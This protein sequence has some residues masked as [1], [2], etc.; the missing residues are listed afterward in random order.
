[1]KKILIL[2]LII[3]VSF[4]F[5]Q[6]KN[7][8][9]LHKKAGKIPNEQCLGCHGRILKEETLDGRFK[10]FHRVHLESELETP[11]NCSDC[12]ESVDLREGSASALRKQ[13]DPGLC[14]LCHSGGEKGLKN[15]SR[16][17]LKARK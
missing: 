7:L 1:M 15:Y 9:D 8:I 6:E 3:M 14:A 16:N 4:I 2:G 5:A 10:T 17:N 12:H 11:K 13:V